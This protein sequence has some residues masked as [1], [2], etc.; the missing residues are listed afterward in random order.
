MIEFASEAK[1]S[2]NW[3][4]LRKKKSCKK[5]LHSACPVSDLS[6]S[7]ALFLATFAR[8]LPYPII[9]FKPE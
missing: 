6:L 3:Y 2:K 1:S 7:Q 4:L 9:T 5:V 8:S